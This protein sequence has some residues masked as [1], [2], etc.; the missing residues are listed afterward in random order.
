[1]IDIKFMLM[2]IGPTKVIKWE[3]KFPFTSCLIRVPYQFRKGTKLSP[4]FIGLFKI[5][6][7]IGPVAYHLV[8]P[9]H[10]Q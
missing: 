1:M 10:L 4:R 2:H 5:Q 6:E 3:T 8:L 9:P 7:K